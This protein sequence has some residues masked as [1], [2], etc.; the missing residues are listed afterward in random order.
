MRE[1]QK[2]KGEPEK[3]PRFY[4]RHPVF[5]AARGAAVFGRWRPKLPSYLSCFV[6]LR[7]RMQGW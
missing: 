1:A 3:W 2:Y 7:P 4:S 6:D 5:A